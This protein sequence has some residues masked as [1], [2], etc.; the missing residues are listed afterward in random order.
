MKVLY[1]HSIRELIDM[2]TPAALDAALLKMQD[3]ADCAGLSSHPL[4]KELRN[5]MRAVSIGLQESGSLS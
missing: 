4:Y 5:K 2:G 3:E 1:S